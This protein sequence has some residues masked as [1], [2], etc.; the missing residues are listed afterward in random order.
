MICKKCGNYI[1]DNETKCSRCGSDLIDNENDISSSDIFGFSQSNNNESIEENTYDYFDSNADMKGKRNIIIRVLSS[2]RFLFI[3]SILTFIFVCIVVGKAFFFGN[4]VDHYEEIFTTIEKREEEEAK[5]YE[6]VE[7]DSKI[8]KKVAASELVS[9][10]NSKIDISNM[11]ESVNK[12][13]DQINK[14][15]AE[16]NNYFAFKYVDIYTGFSVSYNEKQAIFA[17]SSIKAPKDIYLYEMASQGKINLEDK[18]V[19]TSNYYNTGSGLLKNR[20]INTS[21]TVRELLKLSTVDSDNAAHNMLMDKYGRENILKFWKKHDT[22]VI[23]TSNT[24]WG[25]TS[26][27]DASIYMKELYSFYVS[28]DKY[29]DE[30]MSNFLKTYPK[31]LN[32]KGHKIASKSGWSGSS[33]HDVA[34]VFADNPYIVVALSNLGDKNYQSYFDKVSELAYNLHEEYWKYKM[35]LCNSIKQY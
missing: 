19:Y 9:C 8:L 22:D 27:H 18:L 3:I 1:G 35:S 31:F 33:L 34:I 32:G 23:F 26:A 4:K 16:S 25:P 10:I 24:N 15:Y 7:I 20:S 2:N 11:S 28:N 13:V 5:V 12:A 29:G 21:Y 6:G 17:A 14:Y 30:L